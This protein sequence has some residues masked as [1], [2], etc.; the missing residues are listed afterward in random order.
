AVDD[1]VQVGRAQPER[2]EVEQRML[3]RIRP[4]RVEPRDEVAELA[5][6]MDE[7]R[8]PARAG[9]GPGALPLLAQLETGEEQ[10]PWL[11]DR[12]GVLPPAGVLVFDVVRVRAQDEVQTTGHALPE[13]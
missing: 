10:R 6:R 13:K 3:V 8:D 11:G 12:I 1:A 4:E 5:V 9:P 7:T 2:G